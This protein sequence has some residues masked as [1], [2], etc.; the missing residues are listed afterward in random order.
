[1]QTINHGRDDQ[2]VTCRNILL[3]M[4]IIIIGGG[5]PPS[6][7]LLQRELQ[8][9][10]IL[11]AV[12]AG[13]NCLFRHKIF[14]DYII[15]DCDSIT[16]KALKYFQTKAVVFKKYPCNKDASDTFLAATEAI[17]LGATTITL[18]G[19]TQ[20]KR[21]DHLIANL[22]VLSLCSDAKVNAWLKDRHNMITLLNAPTTITGKPRQ[23]FSLQAFADQVKNLSIYGSKYELHDHTLKLGDT[24]TLSNEFL[25]QPVTINFATGK[26]LLLINI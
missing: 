18:L 24:L 17:K 11:I 4:K 1:M 26:L 16:P 12:D 15:G 22:G 10:E 13:A 19:C 9:S 5:T 21:I 2:I 3:N 20:G 23:I 25:N 8:S 7:S 14:P 6:K